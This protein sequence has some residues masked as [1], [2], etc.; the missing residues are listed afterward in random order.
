MLNTNLKFFFF[1]I[2][3]LSTVVSVA[4]LNSAEIFLIIFFLIISLKN[5]EFLITILNKDYLSIWIFFLFLIF[6]ST[7]INDFNKLTLNSIFGFLKN[8]LF[9]I[10]FI[11]FFKKKD[12]DLL[13]KFYLFIILIL[14]IDIIFQYIFGYNFIG[15]KMSNFTGDPNR[16]SSF[17]GKELV[18]GAFLSK[19]IFIP[20]IV[21]IS[22]QKIFFNNFALIIFFLS[23]VAVILT[24]DRMATINSFVFSVIVLIFLIKKR[25]ILIIVSCLVILLLSQKNLLERHFKNTH[26]QYNQIK[27]D[28]NNLN[29]KTES[30]YLNH[31]FTAIKLLENNLLFGNGIRSFRFKCEDVANKDYIFFGIKLNLGNGCSTHPHNYYLEIL[32]ETGII[33]LTLLV[34]FF[35][36]NLFY[37]VNFKPKKN[38]VL[39]LSILILLSPVQTTGSFFTSW[40]SFFIWQILAIFKILTDETNHLK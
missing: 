11:Y 29:N 14:S 10:S 31:Y 1:F 15:Y 19:I 33:G 5:K 21:Y 39:L 25:Y 2:L 37:K 23:L 12:L 35:L 22:D 38:L 36:Y 40:N 4:I 18:A 20:I 8:V 6:Q 27:Y 32:S 30:I 26:E 24:G 7:F 34:Y 9:F 3:S 13:I 16:V 28:L 17:F